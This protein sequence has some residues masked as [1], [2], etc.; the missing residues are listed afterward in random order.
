MN[1][2][3]FSAVGIESVLDMSGSQDK[4][5]WI[6]FFRKNGKFLRVGGL[7]L[8]SPFMAPDKRDISRIFSLIE[9][10][11]YNLHST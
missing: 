2:F 6:D 1:L 5:F 3:F 8:R 7:T 10:V 11:S 9:L 4:R